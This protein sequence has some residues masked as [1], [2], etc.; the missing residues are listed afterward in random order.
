MGE[1]ITFQ[2]SLNVCSHFHETKIYAA[3]LKLVIGSEPFSGI[4]IHHNQLIN[5]QIE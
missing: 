4:N 2:S 1:V 5:E 3:C